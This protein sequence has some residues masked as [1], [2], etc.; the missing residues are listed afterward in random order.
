MHYLINNAGATW[1]GKFDEYPDKAW[2][3]VM[4]LNV[5]SV[6]NLTKMISPLLEAAGEVGDPARVVN[7]SSVGE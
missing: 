6:F 5:R 7:I 4:D 3:R 2:E 1:G